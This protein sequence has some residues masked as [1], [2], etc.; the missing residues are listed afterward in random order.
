MKYIIATITSLI[1]LTAP[2]AVS[3]I[4]EDAPT[5][6]VE[7]VVVETTVETV[8]V[9]TVVECTG[10]LCGPAQGP[11]DTTPV[12]P[13]CHISTT[14]GWLPPGQFD[15]PGDS[16]GTTSDLLPCGPPICT[17]GVINELGGCEPVGTTFTP[18][19]VTVYPLTVTQDTTPVVNTTR[20]LPSTGMK[21]N[22]T[23]IA[24]I[25]LMAGSALKLVAFRKA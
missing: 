12:N 24:L 5:T 20:E 14:R 11:V 10:L 13:G 16:T 1:L 15:I 17:T 19:E 23:G 18:E 4:E 8:P 6:T 9:T 22:I 21:L 7:D 25:L 2:Q 3:A